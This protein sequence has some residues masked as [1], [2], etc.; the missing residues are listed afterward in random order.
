MNVKALVASGS[1]EVI[2]QSNEQSESEIKD[3]VQFILAMKN[4]T[5]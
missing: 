2:Q 5:L 4:G 3:T 1:W